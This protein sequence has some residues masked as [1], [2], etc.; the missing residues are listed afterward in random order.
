M[1]DVFKSATAPIHEQWRV[2]AKNQVR[3]KDLACHT[4][5]GTIVKPLYTAEIMD[6][7]RG[8]H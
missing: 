3:G 1:T 5:Q 7:P 6:A 2:A 4:P 8:E